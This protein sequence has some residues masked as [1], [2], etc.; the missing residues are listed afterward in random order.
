MQLQQPGRKKKKERS[1]EDYKIFPAK[2]DQLPKILAWVRQKAKEKVFTSSEIKKIELAVE[3]AVVNIILHAYKNVSGKIYI[4]IVL[5]EDF[6][7]ITIKDKGPPFNL[8]VMPT[9][10]GFPED[11]EEIEE[12]G[13]GLHLLHHCMDELQYQRWESYN[14]LIMKK[15]KKKIPSS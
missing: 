3:E 9:K 10:K 14:I 11:V 8:L 12:G 13:L 5:F 15:F 1:L 6:I 2:I 7:E 4:S